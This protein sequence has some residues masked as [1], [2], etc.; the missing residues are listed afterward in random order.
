MT[1]RPQPKPEMSTPM[2]VNFV[3]SRDP[4]S[5]DFYK[6]A[7]PIYNAIT[8]MNPTYKNLVGSCIFEF[9]QK[10]QGQQAPKI[11]GMLIDLPVSE[12]QRFI[13]NYDLFVQRVGQAHTLLMKTLN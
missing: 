13:V 12:I 5:A 8:E 2:Q 4:A 1:P 6:K 9:V 3:Q 7:M 10:L 11:T